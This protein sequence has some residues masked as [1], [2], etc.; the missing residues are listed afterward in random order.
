ML[1]L[2]DLVPIRCQFCL[3]VMR[4]LLENMS[5]MFLRNTIDKRRATRIFFASAIYHYV[6]IDTYFFP[7]VDK[8]CGFCAGE[9]EI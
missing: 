1:M 3:T 7:A 8:S 6:Q 4:R 9:M 2:L 5:I